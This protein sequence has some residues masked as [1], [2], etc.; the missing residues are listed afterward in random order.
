VTDIDK[1]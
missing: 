1:K